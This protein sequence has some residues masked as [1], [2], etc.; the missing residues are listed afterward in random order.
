MQHFPKFPMLNVKFLKLFAT[1]LWLR[2]R[3]VRFVRS[4]NLITRNW[5]G[6]VMKVPRMHP[7]AALIPRWQ[8][9][10]AKRMFRITT[11]TI[12][13]MKLFCI[14]TAYLLW[15]RFLRVKTRRN[16]YSRKILWKNNLINKFHIIFK[17]MI[18]VPNVKSVFSCKI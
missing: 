7:K 17:L 13:T 11:N 18:T 12:V 8:Y 3:F 14:K 4:H 1:L 2:A 15:Y 5:H 16:G 10:N 6:M 9:T